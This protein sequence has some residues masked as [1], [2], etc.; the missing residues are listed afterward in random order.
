MLSLLGSGN[1]MT[2]FHEKEVECEFCCGEGEV[3]MSKE[4]LREYIEDNCYTLR[5][6]KEIV[7]HWKNTDNV[8]CAYCE[9]VG[10][11]TERW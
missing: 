1:Y 5:E 3:S 4:D 2:N 8:P 11:W 10:R 9:G 6:G 7:R